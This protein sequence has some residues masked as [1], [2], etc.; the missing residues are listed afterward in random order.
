MNDVNKFVQCLKRNKNKILSIEDKETE[1]YR[2]I[3]NKIGIN[4]AALFYQLSRLLNLPRLSKFSLIFIERFFPM[5][6]E[7]RSFLELDY[8]CVKNILLSSELHID[9]ELE[10]FNAAVAWLRHKAVERSKHAKPILLAI[11][12]SLLSIATLK[13]ILS[14]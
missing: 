14:E 12:L 3:E 4:N 1:I 5:V 11:R 10:A 8:A 13:F 9:S 7:S 2:H 6:V